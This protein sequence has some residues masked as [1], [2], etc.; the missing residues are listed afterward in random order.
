MYLAKTWM[1]FI[2]YNKKTSASFLW[3]CVCFVLADSWC[4]IKLT[5][6]LVAS[7]DVSSRGTTCAEIGMMHYQQKADRGCTFLKTSHAKN[8]SFHWLNNSKILQWTN[9]FDVFCSFLNKTLLPWIADLLCSCH[10]LWWLSF[11]YVCVCVCMHAYMCMFKC[12]CMSTRFT[13]PST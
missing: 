4:K 1:S 13:A 9:I 7:L 5:L 6:I 3:Y 12:V 2:H 10:F 8:I 11:E